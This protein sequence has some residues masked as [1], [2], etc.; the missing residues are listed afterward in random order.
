MSTD[1]GEGEDSSLFAGKNGLLMPPD[2]EIGIAVPVGW[3]VPLAIGAVVLVGVGVLIGTR[4]QGGTAAF[5]SS[6]I[7][8]VRR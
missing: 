6:W 7:S 3:V 1:V 5:S 8:G 2:V 4:L